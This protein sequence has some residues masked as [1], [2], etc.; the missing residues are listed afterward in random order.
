MQPEPTPRAR[1][2][3]RARY[4]ARVTSTAPSVRR[5]GVV[6][7]TSNSRAPSSRS[8][9]T[10]AQHA[11]FDASVTRWNI[12]SPANSPPIAQ[13]VEPT[14]QLVVAP[15]L[16][17]V[18][19]AELVQPRVRVARTT[20][21]SNRADGA[22][23]RTRASPPRTRCRPGSRSAGSPTA[24]TGSRGIRRAGSRRADRRPP[25]EH[26]LDAH[27]EQPAPVRVEHRSRLEIAA[28]RDHVVVAVGGG[29]GSSQ[30][31]GGGS[32][33]QPSHRSAQAA[34]RAIWPTW[35]SSV[36]A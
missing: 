8:S 34:P 5:C 26:A 24:A 7:C 14:D 1:R 23:R 19:P 12:D 4:S 9:S 27:R 29:S 17:T 15:H 35:I 13:P 18:R 33:G 21:R 28:D 22:D 6:H 16:D 20:R 36:P 31:D 30:R 32:T 25:R 2:A 3:S 10:V 11:T